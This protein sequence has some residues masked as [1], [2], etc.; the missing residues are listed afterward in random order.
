MENEFDFPR[1]IEQALKD[2]G[3]IELVQSEIQNRPALWGQDDAKTC[4]LTSCHI[5]ICFNVKDESGIATAKPFLMFD[6][7]T[8]QHLHIGMTVHDS[9]EYDTVYHERE[10]VYDNKRQR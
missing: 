4:W 10:L 9:T 5:N 8:M 6:I 1:I 7:G 3:I 2:A